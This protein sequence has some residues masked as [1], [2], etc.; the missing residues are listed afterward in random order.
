MFSVGKI[1]KPHGLKGAL[2]VYPLTT[3]TDRFVEGTEYSCKGTVLKLQSAGK[4]GSNLLLKFEGIDTREDAEALVGEELL[5]DNDN[6]I[7]LE[8]DEY[9]AHDL[10]G[11]GVYDSAGEKLGTVKELIF[12]K[13]G[14][15]LDIEDG[16][17]GI[18]VLFRKEELES[19]NTDK[20]EIRLRRDKAYYE[21]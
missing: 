19:V 17:K 2:K 6:L 15:V 1:V 20:K 18:T 3:E 5:V 12:L 13:H 8:D 14:T 21:V 9:Y 16:D 10:L 4:I 11:C 7:P